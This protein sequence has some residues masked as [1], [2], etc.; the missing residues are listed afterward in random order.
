MRNKKQDRERGRESEIPVCWERMELN[1]HEWTYKIGNNRKLWQKIKAE[2]NEWSRSFAAIRE[3]DEMFIGSLVLV[4]WGPHVCHQIT[5]KHNE[6]ARQY[7]ILIPLPLFGFSPNKW[8][9]KL[10]LIFAHTAH[11]TTSTTAVEKQLMQRFPVIIIE[12]LNSI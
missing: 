11:S 3:F 7:S 1:E 6:Y 9:V 10:S 2:H 8:E 12:K 5:I 4:A